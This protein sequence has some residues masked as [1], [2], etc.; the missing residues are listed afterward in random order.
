MRPF[1]NL[2]SIAD[3]DCIRILGKAGGR[4]LGPKIT[5]VTWNMAKARRSTFLHDVSEIAGQADLILLQ[6]AVLHGDRAHAFHDTSGFEWIMGQ[7]FLHQSQPITTGV[8]TGSRAPSDWHAVIR[9]LD[10]E[11]FIE[12]PKAALATRYQLADNQ[13][14]LAINI[15]A[16]NFVSANK[17]ARMVAQTVEM[18]GRHDGPMILAGD[19]NTW[20]P[21]RRRILAQTTEKLGMHRV[22]V[23]ARRWQH[24]HQILDHVFYRGLDLVSA[25]PFS[26][27]K[28]SDHIPLWAEFAVQ[29][30]K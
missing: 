2:R 22:P 21:R 12:T 9:S 11:P 29:A 18:I 14:L 3:A 10:R 15:H 28:S 19:F 4:T 16:I 1:N 20:N 23:Q 27:I 30:K 25:K 26:H 17:F 6:E 24:F 7:S 8:K 5:V 13:T